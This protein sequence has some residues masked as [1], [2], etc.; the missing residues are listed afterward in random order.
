MEL[1]FLLLYMDLTQPSFSKGTY[2]ITA[3]I[4]FAI[5]AGAFFMTWGNPF[6]IFSPEIGISGASLYVLPI[7]MA[8]VS[9]MKSSSARKTS[10]TI[11]IILNI[12]MLLNSFVFGFVRF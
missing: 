9:F 11:L 1:T 4:F 6:M 12:F 10:F 3:I 8:C 2:M 7:L 5:G